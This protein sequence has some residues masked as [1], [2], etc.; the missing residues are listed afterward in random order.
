MKCMEIWALLFGF[1]LNWFKFCSLPGPILELCPQRTLLE[2]LGWQACTVPK[3]GSPAVPPPRPGTWRCPQGWQVCGL[4]SGE[5]WEGCP[6]KSTT[7][8]VGPTFLTLCSGDS[9]SFP[10]SFY[11]F[12]LFLSPLLTL[13]VR[14]VFATYFPAGLS[15]F[16]KMK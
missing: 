13:W 15:S 7:C 2:A 8:R 3:P 11:P 1:S 5:V 10:E 12:S 16:L 4:G 6:R 14:V 9:S